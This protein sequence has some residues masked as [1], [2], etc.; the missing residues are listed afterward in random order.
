MTIA[1]LAQASNRFA[2]V[3]GSLGVARGDVV[4]LLL[5]RIPDVYVCT[6]GALKAGRGGIAACSP[7][8]DP[9][10]LPRG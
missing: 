2:N 1:E 9:S 8:S 4:F 10:P 6:L 5:P 3:L 7:R